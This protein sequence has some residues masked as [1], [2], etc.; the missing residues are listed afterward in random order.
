MISDNAGLCSE[1]YWCGHPSV[2]MVDGRIYFYTPE[3]SLRRLKL[4]RD[5]TY[6]A[7]KVNAGA[8]LSKNLK[9]DNINGDDSNGKMTLLSEKELCEFLM[10][11][12]GCTSWSAKNTGVELIKTL[13][14]PSTPSYFCLLFCYV[15]TV[16]SLFHA[17]FNKPYNP[18]EPNKCCLHIV[19]NLTAEL[20]SNDIPLNMRLIPPQKNSKCSF[21]Y[22]EPHITG[23]HNTTTNVLENFH[24][25]NSDSKRSLT[26]PDKT[27]TID[28]LPECALSANEC[29]HSDKVT[30]IPTSYSQKSLEF[31]SDK[32]EKNDE[33]FENVQSLYNESQYYTRY[34]PFSENY[35]TMS[36]DC[37]LNKEKN[38]ILQE[39]KESRCQ[40]TYRRKPLIRSKSQP[41]YKS[42]STSEFAMK[43]TPT[44]YSNETLTD[45][46]KLNYK[47]SLLQSDIEQ[48][49]SDNV[50]QSAKEVVA[51]TSA[52]H[53]VSPFFLINRYESTAYCGVC[54][55]KIF[56]SSAVSAINFPNN[57][58]ILI[59]VYKSLT[60]TVH[61]N[62]VKN[63]LVNVLCGH[64][65]HGE[66]LLNWFDATCPY[67]RYQQYP[68]K[69]SSCDICGQCRDIKM[70]LI[71]GFLGCD[72]INPSDR[73][74]F[75][76]MNR[77][78]EDHHGALFREATTF[79]AYQHFVDFH[80]VYAIEIETQRV[81]DFS[82]KL[83]VH[84][85]LQSRTDGKL[86]EFCPPTLNIQTETKNLSSFSLN[87]THSQ[88]ERQSCTPFEE[89]D[90]TDANHVS[91]AL[92]E[93]FNTRLSQKLNE[94]QDYF[95]ELLQDM[96][97]IFDDID[98]DID[99]RQKT[100]REEIRSVKQEL[101]HLNDMLKLEEAKEYDLLREKK[102]LITEKGNL[103]S[104]NNQLTKKF[105]KLQKGHSHNL[106]CQIKKTNDDNQRLQELNLEIQSLEFHIKTQEELVRTGF[107][108][109]TSLILS[110]SR[111]KLVFPKKK[112]KDFVNNMVFNPFM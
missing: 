83:Y 58:N 4:F 29:S 109:P 104:L 37:S 89:G 12:Q 43:S 100:L 25:T 36:Y 24:V 107:I 18:L 41:L 20:S 39:F 103:L 3:E 74:F 10:G 46:H 77:F 112:K 8:K 80:H 96:N 22:H 32:L 33:A 6:F 40:M 66:C 61:T 1:R 9:W 21:D 2:E 17:L 70:C 101:H 71:C 110:Y 92:S 72:S 42:Y 98:K 35:R 94:Q 75:P 69:P 11:Q 111:I 62:R 63:V 45:F 88:R 108:Q 85:L 27:Y 26:I 86:V 52:Y 5:N 105:Q 102:T 95:S 14:S 53:W 65:F 51:E 15:E 23:F 93:D 16:Y 84:R 49:Q 57:N 99:T 48:L 55:E 34:F 81:W 64:T 67:C 56:L 79:H 78:L 44:R 68:C 38:D 76:T 50:S 59:K 60:S 19:E 13:Y 82:R 47:S 90:M 54:L 7:P 30:N 28:E 73:S 106:E 97:I 87:N 31:V 91:Y